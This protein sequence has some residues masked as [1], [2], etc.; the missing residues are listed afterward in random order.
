MD[1]S[2]KSCVLWHDSSYVMGYNKHWVLGMG[3]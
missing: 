3:I 1:V 2:W